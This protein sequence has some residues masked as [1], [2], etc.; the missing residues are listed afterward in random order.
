MR[1]K[2]GSRSWAERAI[3]R[4]YNTLTRAVEEF[5]PQGDRV[6]IYVCGLTPSAEAHLGHARSFMFFDVLRRY[7]IHRGYEV[8]FMQN[9]TDIDDRS[10]NTARE[11]GEDWRAIVK[12]NY[13]SFRDSMAILA[14]APA[15]HEPHATAYIPEIQA[16]IRELVAKGA[17]YAS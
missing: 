9:V 12:R 5:T 15:D 17:A 16:M 11:T 3:L 8:T 13:D 7:L 6:K 4:L 2:R 10:I 1:S 14:V